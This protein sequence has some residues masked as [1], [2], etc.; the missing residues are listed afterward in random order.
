MELSDDDDEREDFSP[1]TP[2][3]SKLEQGMPM[4]VQLMVKQRLKETE[5]FNKSPPKDDPLMD[6]LSL[7]SESRNSKTDFNR[8][9]GKKLANF[10]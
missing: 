1:L 9:L 5:K 3:E 2:D 8:T 4:A 10:K 6:E 7:G